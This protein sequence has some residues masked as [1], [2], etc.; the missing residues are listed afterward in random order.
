M[1]REYLKEAKNL[2]FEA[3]RDAEVENW[4]QIKA[5]LDV[6]EELEKLIANDAGI[7]PDLEETLD[8]LSQ[9]LDNFNKGGK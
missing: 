7:V 3:W 8:E 4:W 9:K 1:F 6:L 5:K 2:L